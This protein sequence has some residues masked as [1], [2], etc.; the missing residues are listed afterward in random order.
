MG[1]QR[2]DLLFYI[3]ENA[4]KSH[5]FFDGAF[6][7]HR[8]KSDLPPTFKDS[9]IH[10]SC[11]ERDLESFKE[12]GNVIP[13]KGMDDLKFWK[14]LFSLTGAAHIAFIHADSPFF[15]TEILEE[16]F[17]LHCEFLAEFTFSENL[18]QGFACEIISAALL[19]QLPD[20]EEETLSLSQVIKKNINQFD[21]ELY[22]KSPD[23]RDKRL[24][25]SNSSPRDGVIMEN[26]FQLTGKIPKY[27]DMGGLIGE[28]PGTLFIGPSYVEVEI[29]GRSR[30][31]CIFSYRKAME[32]IHEDMTM[33][34]LSE[35]LAGL[36]E[37]GNKYTI[38]FGG[39][40]DPMEH[41]DFYAM[42][43]LVLKENLVERMILETDGLLADANF[44]NFF[45]K[46]RDRLIV[47]FNMNGYD[48]KTYESIHGHDFFDRVHDNI[49]SLAEADPDHEGIYVQVMKINETN[50]FD[51]EGDAKSFLD[52]Y[53][54]F[55]E[56]TSIPIILQKQNTYL[57]RIEDRRYS[58][59]SPVKRTPC[60]H[61]Q[62]DLYVLS[63]GTV[64]F[65]KQDIDGVNS[66][67]KI[68]SD[69]LKEIWQ[70]Q[71]DFFIKDYGGNLCTKPDCSL[72]DEWY[73]FNF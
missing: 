44:K 5:F 9:P 41:P 57:G 43:E 45:E 17:E 22:Y 56:N 14:E 27:T 2:L 32:N 37:M 19:K 69:S 39:S 34:T 24:S 30:F 73:T 23:I 40:G 60:W 38:C 18:P 70:R 13:R 26:L 64:A 58:D 6:I 15:D 61:L 48:G 33:E 7:P 59:L 29:T 68:G 11:H 66:H 72:C 28:N 21:V 46:H 4:E 20:F 8:I 50:G 49:I 54:D 12:Y 52:K 10:I 42:T 65:C 1:D 16:I 51:N 25:F 31:D 35:L 53:Y 71:G 47:I 63:D 3:D 67:G 55:W 62:R 36:R